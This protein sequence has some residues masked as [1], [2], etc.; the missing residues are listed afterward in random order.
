MREH[1]SLPW[2]ELGELEYVEES[3]TGKVFEQ[4]IEMKFEGQEFI[5]RRVV[6]KLER[7]TRQGDT[8]VVVLTNL[9]TTIG[10][11]KI[12][13]LYLKRWQ[14][15]N[16]FQTVTEVFHC[17][18]KTLGYPRAALFSFA[19]ALVTY[20]L[21]AVLMASLRS[22]HG[23]DKV[24]GKTS[25]YYLAEEIQATYHGMTIALP[26]AVWQPFTQMQLSQFCS[27]LQ[28][29]AAQVDLKRFA[30][31]V[32]KKPKTKSKRIFDPQR[33]HVSTARLLAKGASP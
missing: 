12:T 11:L 13:E 25:Y 17:E 1:E 18:I 21:F 30:S 19:M 20:N 16:L 14:V 33:P 5:V 6:V 31:A 29:W 28:Q 32:K 27:T 24:D 22:V 4:E 7:P 23:A 9:P 15:E 3:A 10:A 2:Q 8:E 26:A